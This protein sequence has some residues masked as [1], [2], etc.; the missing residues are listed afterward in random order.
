RRRRSG[1]AGEAFEGLGAAAERV[2]QELQRHL[3]PEPG[4]AGAIDDTHAAAAE[5]LE[6][7]V[8]CDL[9][10]YH[11]ASG[12]VTPAGRIWSLAA[13]GPGRMVGRRPNSAPLALVRKLLEVIRVADRP[14]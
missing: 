1:L 8:M 13:G 2:G 5:T 14:A 3:A 6:D 4:V 12:H 9:L 11:A 7:G 10:A